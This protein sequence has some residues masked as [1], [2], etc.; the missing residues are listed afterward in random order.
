M[1][2][3][4]SLIGAGPGDPGLITAKGLDR[5]REAQVVVYDALANPKLL[6]QAP[7]DARRIDVGKRGGHHK[8]TQEQTNELLVELAGQG[9]RVVRLKGGDPYLYGRGAEEVAYLASHGV[10][11]EVVPGITAGIAAP[12]YAGIPVTHRKLASTVTFVTGH[13]DP[14]KPDT[15]VDYAALAGL[16]SAGGTACFYMGVGRLPLIVKSLTGHGLE[17]QT[18]CAVVQWGTHNKQRSV[19]GELGDVVQ[20]VESSGIG[21]PAIIVVGPVVGIDEPGLDFFTNR[22]LFGQRVL[23]TRTRQQ[24][25]QLSAGLEAAGAQV[26][27]A[28]TIQIVPRKDWQA[29]DEVVRELRRYDWLIL[30]SVN[31]VRVF[32]LRLK[33]IGLDARHLAG[34]MVASVGDATSQAVGEMLSIRPD[35]VPKRT[36]GEALA[37]ELIEAHDLSDK[38]VLLP[39][40]DIARPALPKLL[41]NAGADVDEVVA[42]ETRIADALPE[43]VLEALTRGELDWVTFTSGSTV[44]NLLRLLGDR[45]ELLSRVKTASI[46]PV[47]TEA[48]RAE[49]LDVTVQA[50]QASVDRLVEAIIHSR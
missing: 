8:L 15:S 39:R 26:Y 30:T 45:R 47:T 19:R 40:A 10:K 28:P 35:F 48:M 16:I 43:D 49:S 3:F 22:P 12:M 4:V 27:E 17:A 14:T 23:V 25:S 50:Q 9:L 7:E 2:G 20:R 41:I 13:E 31:A 42:Y 11:C 46:G 36:M 6:E 21:S 44:K 24:A 37:Q 29:Y 34:V 38:R 5:L 18:P 1:T 32:S 33:A